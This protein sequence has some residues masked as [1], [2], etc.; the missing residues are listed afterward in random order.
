MTSVTDFK[1]VYTGSESATIYKNVKVAGELQASAIKVKSAKIAG[2]LQA[3]AIK[4][5]GKSLVNLI[6]SLRDAVVG[7]DGKIMK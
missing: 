4:V 3:D 2:E 6:L 7:E 5:G 1:I